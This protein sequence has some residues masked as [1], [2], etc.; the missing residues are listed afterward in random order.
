[1]WSITVKN[2]KIRIEKLRLEV[3]ELKEKIDFY[4]DRKPAFS[5]RLMMILS[6]KSKQL[7]SLLGPRTPWE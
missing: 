1:M 6:Q 5:R 2:R 4:K 3:R 7:S